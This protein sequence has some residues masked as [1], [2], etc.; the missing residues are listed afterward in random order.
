VVTARCRKLGVS[1]EQ[2]LRDKRLALDRLLGARRI[3]PEATAFVGNDV[4]DLT[5]LEA[6]GL[7]VIVK[8]AHRDV[9]EVALWQTDALGGH[10]AVR[11]VCDRIVA[12]RKEGGSE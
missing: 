9:R 8:D 2:G 7:P 11:E 3:P 4:N 1:C 10:G 5:C 6:V 12:A